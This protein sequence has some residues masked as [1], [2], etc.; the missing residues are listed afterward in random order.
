MSIGVIG[1]P[2]YD[3]RLYRPGPGSYN[4]IWTGV[5]MSGWL[6]KSGRGWERDMACSSAGLRIKGWTK[7][8][9]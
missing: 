3:Y 2:A 5:G 7:D 4:R 8:L 9:S 1:I 6:E